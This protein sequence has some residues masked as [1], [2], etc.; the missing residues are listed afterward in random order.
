MR[1]ASDDPE[2]PEIT[3]NLRGT[4]RPY[5]ARPFGEGD[6]APEITVL[7][8]GGG[9]TLRFQAVAGIT[10]ILQRSQDLLTWDFSSHVT[11]DETGAVRFTDSGAPAEGEFYRLR[12]R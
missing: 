7:P 4:A 3:L 5:A 11:A 9:A 1:I 8:A 6:I 12:A 10:Y 2:N